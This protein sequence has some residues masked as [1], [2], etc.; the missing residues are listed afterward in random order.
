MSSHA[1]EEVRIVFVPVILLAWI[2][3]RRSRRAQQRQKHGLSKR[4]RTVYVQ[5]QWLDPVIELIVVGGVLW[6]DL[7][8]GFLPWLALLIGVAIGGPLGIYRGRFMYV[9]SV[10]KHK[11]VVER[12]LA[13]MLIL[14]GLIAIKLAA[15][16]ISS[17]SNSLINLIAVGLL[18]IGIASSVG[19]VVYIT[20]RHYQS[21][22]SQPDAA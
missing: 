17:N 8:H 14:L 6:I 7:Q 15:H 11:V 3:F 4:Q 10:E 16:A 18:G 13:E 19:R 22:K 2:M 1:L 21:Q 12:N 5:Q 20:V 9:R